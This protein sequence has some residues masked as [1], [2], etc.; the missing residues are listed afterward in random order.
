MY[1]VAYNMCPKML[2][3]NSILFYPPPAIAHPNKGGVP[4]GGAVP[5]RPGE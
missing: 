5:L 1:H 4:Q 2:Q 3:H